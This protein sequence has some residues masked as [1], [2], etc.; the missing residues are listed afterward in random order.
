[1]HWGEIVDNV[2]SYVY[3]DGDDLVIVF[4]FSRAS[5]PFPEDLGKVFVARIPPDEFA[6]A[7]EETA[8]LLNAQ[9]LTPAQER[10]AEDDPSA[11][12]TN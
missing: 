7:L 3:L 11:R 10:F 6:A 8:D 5:H 4:G 2:T 9:F 1:M 12:D